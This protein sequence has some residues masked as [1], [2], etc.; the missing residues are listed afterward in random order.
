[1][2]LWR[3]PVIRSGLL[4]DNAL[5]VRAQD[6]IQ[7]LLVRQQTDG[8]FPSLPTGESD[9]V[10]TGDALVALVRANQTL[11]QPAVDAAATNWLRQRLSNNWFDESERPARAAAYAALAAT[12]RLDVSSLRYFAETSDGKTLPPLAAAQLAAALAKSNDQDKANHWL[13][14]AHE[15]LDSTPALWP[16]L[17]DNPLFDFHD[18]L[19]VLEKTSADLIKHPSHD[20]GKLA[21]FLQAIADYQ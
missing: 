1:M 6:I 12:D 5:Q 19:P 9:L 7:R 13:K 17:A 4:S 15:Q 21:A 11:T 14:A 20:P 3:E 2:R 18:L 16:V 10:S 8:G